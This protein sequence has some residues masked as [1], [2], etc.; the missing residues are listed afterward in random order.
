M[1]EG[2]AKE[3]RWDVWDQRGED[4][5]AFLIQRG[6]TS[7]RLVRWVTKVSWDKL[8][9][10]EVICCFIINPKPSESGDICFLLAFICF[11]L[12]LS[13]LST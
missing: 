4:C 3:I 11:S 7:S 9:L 2:L 13:S 1:L 10:K 12:L 5:I 6:E 8:S